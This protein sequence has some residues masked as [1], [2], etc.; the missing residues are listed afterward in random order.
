MQGD[1]P[2]GGGAIDHDW[3][4][5]R[6]LL[7]AIVTQAVRDALTGDPGAIAWLDSTAADVAV[8]LDMREDAFTDW[9]TANPVIARPKVAHGRRETPAERSRRYRERMKA[10]RGPP[11]V[12]ALTC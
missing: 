6:R 9:R 8:I 4:A 10:Q 12:D 1:R 2:W 7:A 3:R 11:G 5:L